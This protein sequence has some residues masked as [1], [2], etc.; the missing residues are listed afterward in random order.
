MKLVVIRLRSSSVEGARRWWLLLLVFGAALYMEISKPDEIS[1]IW[2]FCIFYW[3]TRFS[4]LCD[5]ILTFWLYILIW[6]L[7]KK[8]WITL[9]DSFPPMQ[10]YHPTDKN[11]LMK[12]L[13]IPKPS[14]SWRKSL[15]VQK[16]S[17]PLV[18]WCWQ[19]TLASKG[20]IEL[21]LTLC[22]AWVKKG[23]KLS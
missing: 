20:N 7:W 10:Y 3:L 23:K 17:F 9:Y 11:T 5:C 2:L 6:S 12:F 21:W 8:K 16:D 1:H 18:L 15:H 13:P 22:I 4:I 19:I 14:L